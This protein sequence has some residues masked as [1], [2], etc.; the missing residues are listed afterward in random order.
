MD[1]D[2]AAQ[3]KLADFIFGYGNSR[4][5]EADAK[6]REV[7]KNLTWTGFRKSDNNQLL[8]LRHMEL[9]QELSKV[10]TDDKNGRHRQEGQH[11]RAEGQYRRD[12]KADRGQ[13][14]NPAGDEISNDLIMF[15][16]W[17]RRKP[18]PAITLRAARRTSGPHRTI[19]RSKGKWNGG[20][21]RTAQYPYLGR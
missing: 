4:N 14:V 12:R 20:R 17:C 7:L 16:R 11:R 2:D 19:R 5:A 21:N 8:P 13:A 3:K 15:R 10:Q 6:A 1:L 18:A 9:P